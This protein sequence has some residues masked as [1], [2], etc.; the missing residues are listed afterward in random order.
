MGY[1]GFSLKEISRAFVAA[2][3]GGTGV[4]DVRKVGIVHR[5]SLARFL[6]FINQLSESFAEGADFRWDCIVWLRREGWRR[7][8]RVL[9][10]LSYLGTAEGFEPRPLDAHQRVHKRRLRQVTAR[11]RRNP[12][13]K[14]KPENQNP[15]HSAKLSDNMLP[16]IRSQAKLAPCQILPVR[17]AAT[18]ESRPPTAL[19][20]PKAT[21]KYFSDFILV[22]H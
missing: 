19:T 15:L 13:A 16:I 1:A 6:F 20:P 22:T 21:S 2:E 18:G 17:H 14:L 8:C 12:F 4:L 11:H 3:A 9:G 10:W 5:A 7:F